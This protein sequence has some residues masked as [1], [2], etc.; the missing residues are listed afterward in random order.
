LGKPKGTP[1]QQ[2]KK[3]SPLLAILRARVTRKKGRKGQGK[4]DVELGIPRKK[5]KKECSDAGEDRSN[6]HSEMVRF[7]A[8]HCRAGAR[9]FKILYYIMGKKQKTSKIQQGKIKNQEH[10]RNNKKREPRF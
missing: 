9:D 4:F 8:T 5:R 2:S 7:A 3:K 1:R 10:P 6:I